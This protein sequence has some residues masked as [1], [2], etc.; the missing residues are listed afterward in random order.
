MTFNAL[1]TPVDYSEQVPNCHVDK[2]E[3]LIIFTYLSF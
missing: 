2:T 1:I 3:R